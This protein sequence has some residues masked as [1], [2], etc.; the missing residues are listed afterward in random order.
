MICRLSN[1]LAQLQAR[2]NSENLKMKSDNYYI[3][4]VVQRSYP[5]QFITI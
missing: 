3:F 1:T 4:Y 5:K 2:N